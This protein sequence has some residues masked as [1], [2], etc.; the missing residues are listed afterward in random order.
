[1]SFHSLSV[2]GQT[3]GVLVDL[4]RLWCCSHNENAAKLA[5]Q[6]IRALEIGQ[7]QPSDAASLVPCPLPGLSL[8]QLTLR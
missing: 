6:T 5:R 7:L 8:A 1:M 3:D 4:E 2:G